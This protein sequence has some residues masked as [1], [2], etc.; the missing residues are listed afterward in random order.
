MATKCFCWFF[1]P[2]IYSRDLSSCGKPRKWGRHCSTQLIAQTNKRELPSHW[3][4]IVRPTQSPKSF[5]S[6]CLATRQAR[7]KLRRPQKI[8]ACSVTNSPSQVYL[9]LFWFVFL[10]LFFFCNLSREFTYVY[11]YIP[12]NGGDAKCSL[13]VY[14]PRSVYV[15][16]YCW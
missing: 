5:A 16:I 3:T 11:I 9:T 2:L 8:T 7:L 10:P 12:F 4:L 6:T 15:Y 1:P 14:Q 13:A